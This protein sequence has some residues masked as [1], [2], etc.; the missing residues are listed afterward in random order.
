MF[1]SSNSNRLTYAEFCTG[2]GGF[3]LGIDT[4]NQFAKCVYR[5]EI[6]SKCE[7]TYKKNFDEVFDSHDVFELN[8][9][10]LPTFDML[11]A[12]FPCQP[13]SIAGG[14]EGFRDARGQVIF[15]ILDIISVKKPP[16]VFL[17]NVPNLKN[18]NKGATLNTI[19]SSLNEN[20]YTVYHDILDSANFGLAQ[21]RPRLYIVAFN[22]KVLGKV[23]FAFPKGNGA[24]KT[25]REILVDG[26]NTIPVS[27]RWDEYI[28]YYTKRKGLNELSF[29]PPKTRIALERIGAN[30]ELS[31]CILQIRSSG[32]R[33][34]SL[35][36]QFPTFAVSNSGGGAMIPVLTRERRHI[37]V[38]EIKRLMGFP[39]SFVFPVSRTDSIKQLANAVCPPVISAI[40]DRIMLAV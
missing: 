30:C 18:H 10:Y 36:S 32:I 14:Q 34:F 26:E 4:A 22:N 15:K 11:C 20:G 37:G 3:R 25:I 21:S 24:T 27:D 17:E 12:G 39:D 5:N 23:N 40:T 16:I 38:S 29:A 19:I 9:S 6:D 1:N 7:E 28:D 8:N 33:A 2:I 13:F 31:D 35:D